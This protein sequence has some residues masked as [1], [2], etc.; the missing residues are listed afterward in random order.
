VRS[1]VCGN[2]RGAWSAC[3]IVLG[4]YTAGVG[5]C[6]HGR[7]TWCMISFRIS[8]G[9]SNSRRGPFGAFSFPLGA[10]WVGSTAGDAPGALSTAGWRM[11]EPSGSL[12]VAIECA[13]SGEDESDCAVSSSKASGDEVLGLPGAESGEAMSSGYGRVMGGREWSALIGGKTTR[14][15]H[16]GSSVSRSGVQTSD[17]GCVL[18]KSWFPGRPMMIP[19][20]RL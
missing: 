18:F 15:V 4:A 1:L 6:V 7:H 17:A 13:A 16:L 8:T 9:R 3:G 2:C 10:W 12:C 19:G 20:Q 11:Q 5:A 14:R